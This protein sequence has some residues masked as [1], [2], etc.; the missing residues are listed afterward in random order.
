MNE[1]ETPKA[2]ELEKL[3]RRTRPKN[4]WYTISDFLEWLKEEDIV[5]AKYHRWHIHPE[6][7]ELQPISA[8]T[9][10]LLHAYFGVDPQ[11]LEEERRQILKQFSENLK[12]EAIE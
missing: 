3:K 5:L 10:D 11:K 9:A 12:K 7:Y 8:T 4:Q 1:I 6:E 2:P